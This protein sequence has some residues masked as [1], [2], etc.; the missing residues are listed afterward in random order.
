MFDERYAETIR[1]FYSTLDYKGYH[2]RFLVN[3]MG[4]TGSSWLAKLINSHPDAYCF[5]EGAA[6]R[7]F[8]RTDCRERDIFNFIRYLAWDT[9]HLAYRAFGDVGSVFLGHVVY[10]PKDRFTTAILTRHPLRMLHTR[11]VSIAKGET[12]FT[13]FNA[14]G[15]LRMFGVSLCD[16]SET[17]AHFLNDCCIWAGTA[18]H[19]GDVD[20]LIQIESLKDP[21]VAQDV[22]LKLTGLSYQKKTIE[23][24]NSQIINSRT[25]TENTLEKIFESFTPT[26]KEWY[27]GHVAPLADAVGYTLSE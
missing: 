23:A 9:Q 1:I 13:Q 21:M 18:E 14:D 4:A 25:D 19:F 3:R 7:V 20:V 24:L 12:N 27:A 10:A 22:L 5:L 2:R 26:Q 16:V 8:P 17:D 11:L 15:I 6:R